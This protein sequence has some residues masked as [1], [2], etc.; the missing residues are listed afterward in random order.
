MSS[1]GTL[2][3]ISYQPNCDHCNA[4]GQ[5][6]A[7]VYDARTA[8]GYWAYLCEIHFSETGGKLGVGFGQRLVIEH[9]PE[10]DY[11]L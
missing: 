3:R 11:H 8:H 9:R 2:A 1:S 7:A 6:R 4:K 5:T 10:K